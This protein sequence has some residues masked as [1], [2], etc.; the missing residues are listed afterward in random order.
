MDISAGII[1]V[2]QHRKS[3]VIGIDIGANEITTQAILIDRIGAPATGRFVDRL[4][5]RVNETGLQTTRDLVLA[6]VQTHLVTGQKRVR[7]FMRRTSQRQ[8]I[9]RILTIV[10]RCHRIGGNMPTTTRR[11]TG[12]AGAVQETVTIE[13]AR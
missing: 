2:Q 12:R 1:A 10:Q 4:D 11:F 7:L 9:G 3:V 6:A 13:I 5:K 8:I